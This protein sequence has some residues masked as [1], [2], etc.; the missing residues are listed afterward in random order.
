M[1]ELAPSFPW[2]PLTPSTRFNQMAKTSMNECQAHRRTPARTCLAD[3]RSKLSPGSC[4]TL[5]AL[6]SQAFL[7]PNSHVG[8]EQRNRS[9]VA[10]QPLGS[11]A[12]PTRV[13]RLA[14]VR[15][16]RSISAD[17][18]L[19]PRYASVFV[20]IGHRQCLQQTRSAESDGR[21]RRGSTLGGAPCES[22]LN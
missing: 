8:F 17:E 5:R 22:L 19:T 16:F 12:F 9:H 2:L 6:P 14:A 11:F 4:P 18:L 13:R 1:S 15:R 7:F 3:P 10:I 20:G 21:G